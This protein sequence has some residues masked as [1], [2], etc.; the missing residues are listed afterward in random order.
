M[1]YLIASI[2]AGALAFDAAADDKVI[3]PDSTGF[4]F[5]DVK[6]VKTTPVRDQNQSGTCWCFS[7]NSFL[8]GE[9]MRQGAKPVDLSEMYTVRHCYLD[10]ARKY[11]RMD[12]KVNFSEGGAAHDVPYVIEMYGALPEEAYPGLNYGEDKHVHGELSS[13]L[14]AYLDAVIRVPDRRLSTAWE[15]GFNAIL[16]AY[17]GEVPETFEY[18]GRTYTPKSFAESLSIKP[19]DYIEVTSFTHH[20]FYKPFALEVADNWLWGTMQNV[21]LEE[22]KAIVDNAIDNGYPVAWGADVSEGGFKWRKGYAVIPV[23]KG[24]KDLT[25]TELSRW[26]QLSDKDRQDERYDINGPVEE[27]TVTQESRQAMFD[28]KETTDD[29][30]M[31]IV[32]KAVDQNGNKYYKVQNSWDTNQLYGGY[33]YVSEPYFLAKTMDVMVHKDAVPSAIAAKFKN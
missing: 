20:P 1:K 28:R 21:P 31:V 26:V 6:V 10:K 22:M 3:V 30:G 12:G 18:E 23:E 11:V 13:V 29:H 14:K 17:F 9:M 7:T 19:E 4:K 33:F 16:D 2:L 5:T 25:G 15:K 24:E 32:G 8:E 27:I